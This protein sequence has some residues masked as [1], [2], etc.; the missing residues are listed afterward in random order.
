MTG[1]IRY[2]GDY[3]ISEG[4]EYPQSEE[5]LRKALEDT[6]KS[7]VLIR[8]FLGYDMYFQTDPNRI[9]PPDWWLIPVLAGSVLY[10]STDEKVSVKGKVPLSEAALSLCRFPTNSELILYLKEHII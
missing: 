4:I 6:T 2:V 7:Q 9:V 10:V 8:E 3:I 5:V 1:H